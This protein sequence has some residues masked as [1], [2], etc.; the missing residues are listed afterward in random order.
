MAEPD[1]EKSSAR[2]P[3]SPRRPPSAP[4]LRLAHV[5]QQQF[6]IGRKLV[7]K[8]LCGMVVGHKFVPERGDLTF[9]IMEDGSGVIVEVPR[10]RVVALFEDGEVAF[11]REHGGGGG[12]MLRIFAA[13]CCTFWQRPG[14]WASSTPSP[15]T[16][17]PW[18]S[19]R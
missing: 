9:Q 18:T 4:P 19:I 6:V 1:D 11:D 3:P 12:G 14:S 15:S 8:H 16:S 10:G 17:R 13:A 5:L 7:S 2:P